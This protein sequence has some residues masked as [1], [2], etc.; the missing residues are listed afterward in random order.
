VNTEEPMLVE[1]PIVE[2]P[3]PEKK[4]PKEAGPLGRFFTKAVRWAAGIGLIFGFGVVLTWLVRVVPLVIDVRDL[5]AELTAA[6]AQIS[7]LE[8]IVDDIHDLQQTNAS[9]Q[10]DLASAELHIDLLYI[11]SDISKARLAL[12]SDDPAMADSALTG[13]DEL[14]SILQEAL[15]GEDANTVVGLRG[16]LQQAISEIETDVFAADGDLEILTNGLMVL[17]LK[18]FGE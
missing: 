10:A 3:P 16:R 7:D 4:K 14:M 9:L 6:N 12:A 5:R 2:G 11:L 1:E 8:E 15:E 17:E 18:L 13:T